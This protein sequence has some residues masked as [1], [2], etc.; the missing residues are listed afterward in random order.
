MAAIGT[1]G[2]IWIMGTMENG[3]NFYKNFDESGKISLGT[4]W[5]LRTIG[6]MGTRETMG[7]IGTIGVMGTMKN[8]KNI[9]RN[10]GSYGNY[11]K[12]WKYRLKD[13]LTRKKKTTHRDL[14]CDLKI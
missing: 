5:T 14:L 11:E 4:M 7:T 6:T 12:S 2:A 8:G 1:M 13:L 3:K 9:F 10:Y